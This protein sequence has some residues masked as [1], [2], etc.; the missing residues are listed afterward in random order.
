MA[1]KG[2]FYHYTFPSGDGKK[3]YVLNNDLGGKFSE[4]AVFNLQHDSLSEAF[5]FNVDSNALA[6][7]EDP[8]TAMVK[9]A[10]QCATEDFTAETVT[11]ILKFSSDISAGKL[12]DAEIAVKKRLDTLETPYAFGLI[13]E[14]EKDR[15]FVI[16]TTLEHMGLQV[17][18]M[19]G[20]S[21]LDNIYTRS[22]Y[23]SASG[24][25]MNAVKGQENAYTVSTEYSFYEDDW[26]RFA[27]EAAKRGE[28]EAYL[29]LADQPVIALGL[30]E[31]A[32]TAVMKFNG[33]C[34]MR[35]GKV[36]TIP[37]NERNV[38]KANLVRQIMDTT[39]TLSYL[40]MDSYQMNP[41]LDGTIP[42]AA[43]FGVQD[44]ADISGIRKTISGISENAVVNYGDGAIKIFLNLP[45]DDSL[46][47]NAMKI[48]EQILDA[49][50]PL[51]MDIKTINIYLIDEN[52]DENE[53]ARVFFAKQCGSAKTDD[54]GEKIFSDA[55][56]YAYGIF[57]GGR[58]APYAEEIRKRIESSEFYQSRKSEY[59][60]WTFE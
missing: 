12:L 19:L 10:N 15:K 28:K 52:N 23:A 7:W 46:P 39:G 13:G 49:L 14:G 53:R 48:P 47:D 55:Y 5:Y 51:T 54:N 60:Y 41:A 30:D 24:L 20:C 8:R 21:Y 59:G 31:T 4:L 17:M 2:Y 22:M 57:R 38:W 25:H 34:E 36:R 26:K 1:C 16:K 56:I 58:V 45:A 35:N 50:D 3:F 18:N 32:E 44:A 11:F 29:W 42:T 33:L 27:Q 37:V 43:D 40:Y 6:D 9:G